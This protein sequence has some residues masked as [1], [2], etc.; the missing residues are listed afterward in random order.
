MAAKSSVSW[1][2]INSE[3]YGRRSRR[4]ARPDRLT[5]IFNKFSADALRDYPKLK[6]SFMLVDG[7]SGEAIGDVAADKLDGTAEDLA[8]EL[9]IKDQGGY[10]ETFMIDSV[11]SPFVKDGEI[12][13]II[14]NR[15]M[16]I[17]NNEEQ[18][19]MFSLEHELGHAVVTDA[20]GRHTNYD[21]E[22]ADVFAM[23][24]HIQRH[25]DN[26]G[27]LTLLKQT[28]ALTLLTHGDIH[29]FTNPALELFEQKK[30]SLDVKNM[31]PEQMTAAA[32]D[33]AHQ[34]KFRGSMLHDLTAIV[35]QTQRSFKQMVRQTGR[36]DKS[37]LFAAL[38]NVLLAPET[39]KERFDL[40]YNIILP[41]LE[42]TP[43]NPLPLNDPRW[44]KALGQL[45]EKRQTV[46]PAPKSPNAGH[47]TLPKAFEHVEK[48]QP[49]QREEDYR[50]GSIEDILGGLFGGGRQA[51][52]RGWGSMGFP[53]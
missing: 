11:T 43:G 2:D 28:R 4:A 7:Q 45:E 36:N 37:L 13:S 49:A 23:M 29:H 51:P 18:D 14:Y 32:A 17:S 48:R 33:I 6:G 34:S 16:P 42:A 41:F 1:F 12:Y 15:F 3:G 52:P 9:A 40:G 44:A 25:G 27:Y 21:E 26:D 5:D 30:A 53:F 31:T 46:Q 47:S 35:G 39:H 20:V 38:I 10:A 19:L 24:K 8:R 22:A 50:L